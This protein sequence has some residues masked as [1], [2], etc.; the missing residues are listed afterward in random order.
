LFFLAEARVALH[1]D[2]KLD[3]IV[4]LI[5][6][7]NSKDVNVCRNAAYVLSAAAQYGISTYPLHLSWLILKKYLP[8][9]NAIS[10]CQ[11]GAIEALI[12][13]GKDQLRNSTRF[14][15]DALDRLL[16]YR[17]CKS[18]V[19]WHGKILNRYNH[20]ELS[21]KYWL[22]NNLSHDNITR[23]GFYD[24]GSAGISLTRVK[25]LEP[26][27]NLKEAPI[28]NKREII[29]IDSD[30]DPKFM[31]MQVAASTNLEKLTPPQQIKQIAS[32]VASAM[33]GSIEPNRL[34]EFGYKFK[35]T[36]LKMKMGSNVIPVGQITRGTFYHR[37][38]LFKAICDKI[39]LGPCT[40]VRGEYNRAWNV[41]DLRK[42]KIT[43]PVDDKVVAPPAPLT[44]VQNGRVPSS[45]GKITKPESATLSAASAMAP[46]NALTPVHSNVAFV[47]LDSLPEEP[48]VVDLM[49][50]PGRLYTDNTPEAA[51]YQHSG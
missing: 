50:E 36:E 14:A 7:L 30:S 22:K 48:Q 26:L 20:L 42:Q 27:Q 4:K 25:S 43:A 41:M 33:G 32:V 3:G 39:G 5:S 31:A 44:V 16:N 28:D 37:A 45:G 18:L 21:A 2:K 46:V 15:S 24:I 8:E 10:A 12:T 40:L 51:W 29:L 19:F 9:P 17:M 38:L 47:D 23:N 13:L 49:F 35:I 34:S 11:N 6:L 1:K